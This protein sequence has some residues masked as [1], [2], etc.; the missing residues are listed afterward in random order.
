MKNLRHTVAERTVGS[1]LRHVQQNGKTNS[2]PHS[3]LLQLCAHSDMNRNSKKRWDLLL[4]GGCLL[5]SALLFVFLNMSS[6]DGAGVLVRLNGEEIARY[7]LYE[8]GVFE[9]NGG[10]NTLVIENG[11]A[12]L[13]HATCPDALCVR[14]GKIHANGQTI[15]LADGTTY[16][17]TASYGSCKPC[18]EVD[19]SALEYQASCES[20]DGTWVGDS[21]DNGTCIP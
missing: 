20:C 15:T 8:N 13:S 17:E 10:T 2:V 19:V 9:L 3:S 14:Q 21:W 12:W 16:K 18:S 5:L 1:L 6:E 11:D 7:D 4:I